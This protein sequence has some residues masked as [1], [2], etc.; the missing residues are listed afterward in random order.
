MS[1]LQIIESLCY[2]CDLQNKIIKAQES[3]LFELGAE[4]MEAE[5]AEASE[6]FERFIGNGEAPDFF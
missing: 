1:N 6:K 5:K 4:V 3:V 2:I